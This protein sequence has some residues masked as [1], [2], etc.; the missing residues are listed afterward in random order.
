[1]ITVLYIM[2]LTPMTER[3]KERA[4][5][6]LQAYCVERSYLVHYNREKYSIQYT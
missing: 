1:M 4:V 3:V 2:L 6:N 5:Y